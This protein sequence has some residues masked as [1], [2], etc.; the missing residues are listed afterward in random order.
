ME[1]IKFM[2]EDMQEEAFYVLEQT[3]ENAVNY[4]LVAVSEVDGAQ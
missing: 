1:K 4:L 2:S 3:T